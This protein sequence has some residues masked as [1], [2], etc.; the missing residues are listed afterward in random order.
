[1]VAWAATAIPA[2][3][4]QMEIPA[5]TAAAGNKPS[6]QLPALAVRADKA[7]G[8]LAVAVAGTAA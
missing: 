4:A 5:A 8:L 1:M 2:K 6:T 3:Q 7:R